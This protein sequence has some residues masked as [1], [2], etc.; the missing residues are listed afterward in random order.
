MK[1]EKIFLSFFALLTGLIVAGVAFYFLQ[2]S[3][4]TKKNTT[5]VTV[6]TP[7]PTP[8]PTESLFLSIDSPKDKEVVTKKVVTVTGKTQKDTIVV[9]T[10]PL[11]DTVITPS[12]NGDFK[13]TVS[14]DDGEN[15]IHYIAIAPNGEEKHMIQTIT[16]STED[17]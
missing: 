1:A 15:S 8:T 16:Y 4:P 9:I 13:A 7:S 2:S 11:E 17:F 10:T 14:I 3:N 5:T 6:K 12:Q